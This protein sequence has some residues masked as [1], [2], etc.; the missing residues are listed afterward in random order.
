M[1]GAGDLPLPAPARRAQRP[2]DG[3]HLQQRPGPHRRRSGRSRRG[4]RPPGR[5]FRGR[6][7][8]PRPGPPLRHRELSTVAARV[9]IGVLASGSGTNLQ[10]L[11]DACG[12]PDYP[13]TIAVVISNRRDAFA[14]ERARRAG[15]PAVHVPRFRK[16]PRSEH[17]AAMVEVLREHGVRWV[18]L[19]G[20]MLLVTPTLLDAFP[21]RVLNIHPALLPSFRGL[22]AQ[23]QAL[24]A[25]VR[26][27]G[28]TVHFVTPGMDEGPIICQGAV[29][30]RPDDDLER[31][32]ARILQVEHRLYPLA[33]RQAVE[34]RL[35][36][37]G[38]RVRVDAR[39][40]E[41][42]ALWGG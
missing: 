23:Q 32:R 25:G 7:G 21:D 33:V 1:A 28:A 41:D 20:Y 5:G 24:D 15:I 38:G 2:R 40:G 34:G 11:I 12:E 19:A 18:C 9:P 13:A 39:P 4:H 29:P 6:G 17:D 35:R 31:L 16:R 37:D 36:L 8:S 27:T 30:V 22:H 42:N 26:I 14:L 10:A 3:S